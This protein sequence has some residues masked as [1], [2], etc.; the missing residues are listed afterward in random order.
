MNAVRGYARGAEF[1][2][3]RRSANGLSGWLSYAYGHSRLRDQTTNL[4]FA[5]DFDQRHTV[6]AYG[7]YRWTSTVNLSVKYRYGSN[8]PAAAFLAAANSRFFLAVEKNQVRL[9]AYSRLDV[10]VNKAF[11]RQRL[12][13]TLYGEA[14]NV[15]ARDNYRYTDFDSFNSRTGQVFVSRDTLLPFL[16]VAGLTI[17]F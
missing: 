2:L 6:N 16:P 9:P 17:E 13:L 15:F 8:F 4:H 12:K 3:Q 5:S 1:T 10:R 14:T 11:H 7:S